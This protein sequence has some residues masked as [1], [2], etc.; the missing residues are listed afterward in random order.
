MNILTVANEIPLQRL[1]PSL[2]AAAQWYSY[3]EG[4]AK[5]CRSLSSCA[6]PRLWSNLQ[7]GELA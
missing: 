4:N 2:A 5:L 1:A 3:G 6:T 7:N